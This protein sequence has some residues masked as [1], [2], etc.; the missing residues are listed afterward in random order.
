M[1]FPI[2]VAFCDA[3]GLVLR[4]VSAGAVAGVA[5]VRKAAFVIEAEAGAF[6][7]WGLRR[8]TC[9][10]SGRERAR[11]RRDAGSLARSSRRPIGNLGDLSAARGG[12][13]ARR[14]R[15]RGRGHPP[16]A[17]GCSPTSAC[18]RPPAARGAR[19]QRAGERRRVVDVVRAGRRVAYVTD[20]GM[21]GI[22][23]PG[24][25]LV[26]A[27]VEAGLAV[28]VVPGPSAVTRRAGALG[29]PDRPVRVRGLPPA[30]G[31][32][33]VNA[34][35][36]GRPRRARCVLFESPRR[37]AATL[38]QLLGRADRSARSPSPASSPS[39]TRRCG[40]ARSRR[41]SA[42]VELERAARRA[43]DRARARRRAAGG[44][45][46]RDRRPRQPREG[47]A[48]RT[49][50]A[51]VRP[52]RSAAPPR[53]AAVRLKPQAPTTPPCA[54]GPSAINAPLSPPSAAK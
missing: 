50:L 45:R 7:R 5:V 38:T 40:G 29:L 1:R 14:R 34:R 42:H 49:P 18:P 10:R 33:A 8:A 31:G 23:D 37:G 11:G 24:E 19:A 6:E 30:T 51:R 9:S 52:R 39:S 13:A 3:D 20:A 44:Q 25:R 36:A 2:D 21:P 16:H 32:G 26:R 28:E 12:G 27:C 48:T 53:P 17:A 4:T 35:R 54:S 15:D 46:R 43:R 41:R 47:L 22:S